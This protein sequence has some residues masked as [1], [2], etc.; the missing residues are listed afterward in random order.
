[1]L[2]SFRLDEESAIEYDCNTS[3]LGVTDYCLHFMSKNPTLSQEKLQ[4]MMEFAGKV[5]D[6]Q[7][8]HT[9]INYNLHTHTHPI[10]T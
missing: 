4:L 7:S 1:M 9:I 5:G 6:I 3:I 2:D 8:Q 10:L